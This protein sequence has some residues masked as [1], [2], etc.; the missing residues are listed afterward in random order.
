M[1]FL[2]LDDDNDFEE[3]FAEDS[4]PSGV[5]ELDS[6]T[7]RDIDDDEVLMDEAVPDSSQLTAEDKVELDLEDAPFLEED[8]EEEEEQAEAAPR[9]SELPELPPDEGPPLWKRIVLDQRV[10]LAAAGV[11]ILLL[12][13]IIFLLL[14]ESSPETPQETPAAE[15]EPAPE[16]VPQEAEKAEPLA[17]PVSW[18]P[19]WVEYEM[20]DGSLRFLR[21]KFSAQTDNEKI[22]WEL[23]RKQTV[24][25]DSIYY[26]LRNKDLT[27]LADKSNA[28]ALKR[29]LLAVI[30]QYLTSGELEVLL[31][32]E[33]LIK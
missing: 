10:W 11:I 18:D 28:E 12:G 13:V 29:D 9:P 19:F 6:E 27:F 31:I 24:V 22:A 3:P 32:E 17:H 21:C 8:E 15:V 4:A 26:Y 1:L 25:R 23:S 2:A 30:N 20:P 5:A 7:L 33:Y 14:P 16:E